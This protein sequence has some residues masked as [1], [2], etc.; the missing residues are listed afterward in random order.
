MHD[1]SEVE[2]LAGVAFEPAQVQEF[3][4]QRL[5]DVFVFADFLFIDGEHVAVLAAGGAGQGHGFE[6]AVL[7]RKQQFRRG[8]GEPGLRL[9]PAVGLE[10]RRLPAHG[11]EDRGSGRLLGGARFGHHRHGFLKNPTV[12]R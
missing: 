11:G 9:E 4:N 10:W 6:P 2:D 8:S 1:G 3:G 7:Q 12:D 5:G